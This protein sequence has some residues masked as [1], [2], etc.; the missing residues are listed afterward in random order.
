MLT[1]LFVLQQPLIIKLSPIHLKQDL[2]MHRPLRSSDEPDLG[3]ENAKLA[4]MVGS[5]VDL[6]AK[7]SDVNPNIRKKLL[8][9]KTRKQVIRRH[10]L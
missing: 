6:D 2:R 5:L 1:D 10:T 9:S 8:L 7:F 3:T 4:N